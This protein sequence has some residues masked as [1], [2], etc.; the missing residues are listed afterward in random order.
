MTSPWHRRGTIEQKEKEEK[1]KRKKT[2]TQS[3]LPPFFTHSKSNTKSWGAHFIQHRMN[4]NERRKKKNK[5]PTNMDSSTATLCAH[6]HTK[7]SI[8]NNMTIFLTY[9]F[10]IHVLN[11]P[12]I[13]SSMDWF[14]VS[15]FHLLRP[16]P[17]DTEKANEKK[18]KRKTHSI[19]YLDF[20]LCVFPHSIDAHFLLR[21]TRD[22]DSF[23]LFIIYLLLF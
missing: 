17:I 10:R 18:K 13:L 12:I 4:R 11:T 3:D 21:S 14:C 7:N 8:A 5:I 9:I 2:R 23:R 20:S 1:Q 22:A 19:N 15:S 6:T 16:Q